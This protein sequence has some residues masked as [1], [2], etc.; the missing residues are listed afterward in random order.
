MI[1]EADHQRSDAG[2]HA[3]RH[4]VIQVVVAI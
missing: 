3:V 4:D 1:V 2:V